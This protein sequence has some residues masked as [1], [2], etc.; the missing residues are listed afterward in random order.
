M[1]VS[2]A[3][4]LTPLPVLGPRRLLAKVFTLEGLGSVAGNLMM[5]GI[6]FYMQ[7][8][9]GWGARRNLLL[10]SAQG[11]F[12]VVGALATNPL[13]RRFDPQVLL[14]WAHVGMAGLA[15]SGALAGTPGV[16]VP[17]LLMYVMF[18]A[19]QW[20][21]LES[22]MSMQADPEQLSRRISVYN[23]VWSG[24]G[25]ATVACCGMLIARFPAGIFYVA[26][27]IHVAALG[28]LL[29]VRPL[30]ESGHAQ[31]DPEPEL[32]PLRTLAKR[33]SR[34]A[35]P[36]T[37][38]VIYTLG[39]IMP[40]LPVIQA[41]TPSMRTVLAS[42]WMISR[43]LSFVFLG[44]AAW[45]HTRPRAML[46]AAIALMG[47][48]LGIT[49]VP[50]QVSM[51]FWQIALGVAMALIYSASLYFGMVL[52]EGSTAQNAQHEALIGL[53]S[54]LGPGCGA[55]AGFI[56]PGNAHAPIFAVGLIL[57]LSV[58]AACMFSLKWHR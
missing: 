16:I 10:S 34:I 14:R 2:D 23:L 1:F 39:A 24:T 48:F 47:A 46:I 27:A 45:W 29:R 6:F 7:R 51:I 17:I 55:L 20:P 3:V 18:S 36:A 9:F 40:T 4:L 56:S 31:L 8:R 32:I 52:S 30:G 50:L 58:M 33:L 37:F 22:M 53:G 54:V 57:W 13:S 11:A 26:G 19:V 25:A 12:Y 49:L 15:L 44:A 28:M 43:W 5:F 35:L 42:I 41:A 21:L 38:A